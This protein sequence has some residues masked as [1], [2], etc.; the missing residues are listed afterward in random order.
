MLEKQLEKLKATLTLQE[1]ETI[2]NAKMAAVIVP[3][4]L[5]NENSFIY[6]IKRPTHLYEHAGEIGFPG[7][8]IEAHDLSPLDAAKREFEEELGIS[9]QLLQILREL[10][11]HCTLTKRYCI[12]PFIATLSP[13]HQLSPSQNEVDTIIKL[14][15]NFILKEENWVKEKLMRDNNVIIFDVLYYQQYRIWGVSARILLTIKQLLQA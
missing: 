3:I 7:G 14:P 15:L 11:I 8:K 10:P 12:Y 5:N 4:V 6:L 9:A 13:I 2:P 1:E